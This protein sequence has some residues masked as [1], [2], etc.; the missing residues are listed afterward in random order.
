MYPDYESK[1]CYVLGPGA[2]E[3]RRFRLLY[4]NF[5]SKD[6]VDILGDYEFSSDFKGLVDFIYVVE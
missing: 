5:E 6:T 1:G 2:G 4:Y 3:N